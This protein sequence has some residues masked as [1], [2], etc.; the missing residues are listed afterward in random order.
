MKSQLLQHGIQLEEFGGDVQ[1]VQLSAITGEGI[2]ELEEAIVAEAELRDIRA[3]PR[4]DVRG[5][6]I[7]SKTT[8]GQGLVQT[9]FK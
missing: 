7:E 9:G 4:A 3:D 2:N 5:V 8:K 1:A 6:V